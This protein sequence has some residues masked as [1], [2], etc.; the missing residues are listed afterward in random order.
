MQLFFIPIFLLTNYVDRV[1]R[2]EAFDIVSEDLN[3][4]LTRF[5]TFPAHMR[6]HDN[7]RQ[8]IER[9]ISKRRFDLL[10]VET[11]TCDR[12]VLKSFDKS[13]FID[14]CTASSVDDERGRF[15][16]LC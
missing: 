14:E 7:V 12:A 11:C 8:F 1:A 4:S 9:V 5:K 16:L 3:E 15:Q 2:K 6:R 10:Y 13:R